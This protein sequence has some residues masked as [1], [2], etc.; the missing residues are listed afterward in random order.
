MTARKEIKAARRDLHR[1]NATYGPRMERLPQFAADLAVQPRSGKPLGVWRSRSHLA[2]L[3][4]PTGAGVPRLS[5]CRTALDDNGRFSDGITWD[6]L[7]R[8]KSECGFGDIEAL[9]VYPRDEDVV[10][11]ANQR[12]LW[13]MS[14]PSGLAWRRD[15][16]R[17]DGV[18][19][20]NEDEQ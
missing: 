4:F 11:V 7:Q 8:I 2:V 18:A 13:L 20:P 10:N 6:D 3:W 9:E 19:H 5:V 12:H 16:P 1:T 14:E 15:T 17:P